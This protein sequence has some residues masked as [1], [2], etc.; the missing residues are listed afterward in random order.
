M[1][2][3]FFIVFTG[4]IFT[5]DSRAQS[6]LKSD[7]LQAVISDKSQHDTTRIQAR[8]MFGELQS[9]YRVGYWDSI[10]N[11]C[12]ELVKNQED[13][14]V[15]QALLKVQASAINNV[16]VVYS[17]SGNKDRT[18]AYFRKGV[19]I[20][21]KIG[22]QV[23]VAE[24]L[25]NIGHI[26]ND[27][28]DIV[29]AFDYFNQALAVNE[30]IQNKKGIAV[31]LGK[32]GGIY[33]AQEEVGN[34]LSNQQKAL[35]ISRE[36]NDEEQECTALS[37]IAMIYAEKGDP[38]CKGDQQTCQLHALKQALE[39]YHQSLA[40]A[41]KLNKL[42][43]MATIY[44]NIGSI[45]NSHGDPFCEDDR[46]ECLKKGRSVALIYCLKGIEIREQLKDDKGLTYSYINYGYFNFNV[47]NYH[48][49]EK[50]GRQGLEMAKKIGLP[51]SIKHATFL[52]HN[53]FLQ[54]G[55]YGKALEM[56]KIHIQ[57]RDSL[58]NEETQKAAAKQEARYEYE[59]QKALDD[60]EYEKQLAI[61]QEA[62]QKQQILTF[63]T[64]GGLGLVGIFLLFVFNRLKVTRKQ[65]VAI[66]EAHSELEEK[67]QEILDSINY[68]KRIQSAI[69]PPDKLV[70]EY[71]QDSFILYKPKDI[72]A[73]DF[74]WMETVNRVEQRVMGDG[75][76][77]SKSQNTNLN[78]HDSNL[79]LFAAA[80]C[81][82]H[83]VPGAMVSVVCNNGLN[84]AVREHGLTDP[85]KILDKTREIVVQEF[86][87]SEEDVKDGMDIALC[88]LKTQTTNNKQQTT[89]EYAGANNPLWIIRPAANYHPEGSR[90]D[91]MDDT[92]IKELESCLALSTDNYQLYEIKPDKQPIGKHHNPK[93]YTTH[94]VELRSGDTIYI[95]SDGYADQFGGENGK[96][97][98]TANFKKLVLS[99]QKEDMPTQR[100]LIDEAFENWKGS[101]DQLDDVCVIGVRL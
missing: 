45:Y 24:L 50:W 98:K 89:L 86:E 43:I 46:E 35:I 10:A 91:F 7:S 17:V 34:A 28:G 20:N 100:K 31:C 36:I 4:F 40:I 95:F 44:S 72:V 74:Y 71:L 2:F 52:L 12:E 99:I 56:Y 83:G 94:T 96:K 84:R 93:P 88:S 64:A 65:K 97:M 73:G 80:D 6:D 16:G 42:R 53:V 41:E 5:A 27:H 90:G 63:A 58:I 59:K 70:K 51:Q 26:Y 23:G 87:K 38:D 62:K 25:A 22:N 92:K 13:R 75:T 48:E 49:A 79:I 101:L 57:M 47:G 55:D 69:L 54:K 82:G 60:A 78:T 18:I 21:K 37:N 32:I 85:G 8:A 15:V 33:L 11:S 81:T 76:L 3:F 19:E 68:A 61:E 30:K 9:I 67:N 66:E 77:N 14:Q 29:Q 39:F 1:R